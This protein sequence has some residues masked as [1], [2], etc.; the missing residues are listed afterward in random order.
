[1]PP[2]TIG[3]VPALLLFD[4]DRHSY[5]ING[6]P[7]PSVTQVLNEERFIDFSRIPDGTLVEA[8]A[9]GTYVHQVLHA[10][11]ED[12]F[13]IEDCDPRFRGYVDSA[14]AYLAELKSKPLRDPD[15]GKAI[16]VEYRFW[17][18]PRMFAGTVDYVAWDP[19]GVLAISDFKTSQPSDVAA[20]LQTA[21]YEL[22]IRDCL[23]PTFTEPYT[24]R[25]RRRAVKLFR[26][27]APG[28]A[29]PYA[30]PRDLSLFLCALNCV[31]YRRNTLKHPGGF[32][33]GTD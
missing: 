14:I 17:H 3:A 4:S 19:D 9:R 30:D 1:M 15:T 7:V 29:E 20:A 26:D 22:G 31:H 10:Y 12:D 33:G 23:L 11:L 6:T 18:I 21:A 27:G 32:D 25:I 24:G 13:D 16:A 5:S 28:R 2:R 8:Q